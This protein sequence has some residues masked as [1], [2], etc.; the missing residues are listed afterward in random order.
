M[1]IT[2]TI[3][4][5]PNSNIT[6][7][8]PAIVHDGTR[9]IP[10]TNEIETKHLN[11]SPLIL[12]S[13]DINQISHINFLW[14][15][16]LTDRICQI[17]EPFNFAVGPISDRIIF[18][19]SEDNNLNVYTGNKDSLKLLKTFYSQDIACNRHSS[20]IYLKKYNYCFNIRINEGIF[21]K[22]QS[23]YVDYS[24]DTSDISHSDCVW[25]SIPN[26]MCIRFSDNLKSNYYA[27][28][29]FDQMDMIKIFEKF[30]GI[31]P[32]TQSDLIVSIN[33]ES[34][35]YELYLYRQGLREPLR[36]PEK[37]YQ[38][39]VFKNEF[40]DYRSPNY[41]QPRGAWIW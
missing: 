21:I 29:W 17:D 2:L 7:I 27:Y 40:E 9:I 11:F 8:S 6:N 19:I 15:N 36:I 5:L 1:T 41:N 3:V 12:D 20:S 10:I 4:I 38:M 22:C 37:V 33:H 30:Y 13:T 26:K 16:S 23:V 39:I 14:H 24:Y 18:L 25:R 35:N 32:N 34:N 28:F 31:H